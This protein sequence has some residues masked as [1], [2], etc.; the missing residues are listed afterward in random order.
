MSITITTAA[1]ELKLTQL[2]TVK[3]EF[4][5]SG[6]D[7]D[8][9]LTTL[10][11]EASD[12]MR[13]YTGRKF[14]RESL[15]ET[16]PGTGMVDLFLTRTPVVTLTSV[17]LNN[18]LVPSDEYTL[19][20]ADTGQVIHHD[21]GAPPAAAVWPLS[22]RPSS[23]LSQHVQWGSFANNISVVYV[24]GFLLPGESQ[25]TLPNDLERACIELVKW[26]YERRKGDPS[27]RFE[28]IGD[29]AQALEINKQIPLTISM[30][31]DRWK[32]VTI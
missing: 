3:T 26:F 22:A 4:D 21:D 23:G 12:F 32:Q 2:T 19:E 16:L 31:L 7:D 17:T 8:T 10:I 29:S 15:T 1:S 27:V 24:A 28:K 20:N 14:E 30:I 18:V 5:I 6:S 11:G 9:F 25:P 13:R